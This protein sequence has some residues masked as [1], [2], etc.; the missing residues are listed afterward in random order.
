MG[1]QM[2]VE[3]CEQQLGELAGQVRSE[4]SINS[5]QESV[6]RSLHTENAEFKLYL[7][8]LVRLL[9]AKNVFTREEFERLVNVIDESDGAKDGRYGGTVI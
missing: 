7:A 2:N 8:A 4:Q 3:D 9:I 1:T 6:I 5:M